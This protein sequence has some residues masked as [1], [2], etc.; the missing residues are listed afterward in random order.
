VA[1]VRSVMQKI[2]GNDWGWEQSNFTEAVTKEDC[3]E[4]AASRVISFDIANFGTSF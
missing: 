2:N 1:E 3:N 4:V